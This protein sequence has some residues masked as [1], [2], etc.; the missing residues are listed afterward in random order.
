MRRMRA[1][2]VAGLV[3][4]AGLAGKCDGKDDELREYVGP[5][6]DLYKWEV[7]ITQAV[8]EIEGKIPTIPNSNRWCPS[9]YPPGVTPPPKYPP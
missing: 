3:G 6:G 1:V 4:F 7:R 2:A 9:G 5:N 8:C